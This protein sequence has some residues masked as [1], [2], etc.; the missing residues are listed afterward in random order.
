M[1][2]VAISLEDSVS[3]EALDIDR[4][5]PRHA[6]GSAC[7]GG[8]SGLNR[9]TGLSSN[10]SVHRLSSDL[11]PPQLESSLVCSSCH[12]S[13]LCPKRCHPSRYLP[14]YHQR[15]SFDCIAHSD[16]TSR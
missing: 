11:H 15:A 13:P 1:A 9:L 7:A 2:I 3:T 5:F 10:G 14:C 12:H 6:G 4:G 8:D 16:D